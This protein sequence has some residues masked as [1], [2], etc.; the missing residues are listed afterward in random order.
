M[1]FLS[2][3]PERYFSASWLANL[4]T[5]ANL[6][7]GFVAI[8]MV[9]EGRLAAAAWLILLCLV[10][11]SLDGNAARRLK[12][13]TPFGRELDSLADL[14]SF[15]VAPALL[16]LRICPPLQASAALLYLAAGAY[17]LAR[18]NVRP[19]TRTY[20][21]GLPVPAAAATLASVVLAFSRRHTL[22]LLGS[23][24]LLAALMAVLSVL[25]VSYLRYPKL[26][27]IQFSRWRWLYAGALLVFLA[28]VWRVDVEAGLAWVCLLFAALGPA[29]WVRNRL[30]AVP[31]DS[32]ETAS[33]L[34]R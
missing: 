6:F 27:A 26:S 3:R 4:I 31:V 12:T 24:S 19:A 22:T 5:L 14:V 11:D 7:S 8:L 20:F 30:F 34:S 23:A 25:M 32:C 29:S 1:G 28:S 9:V 18:F 2:H 16:A 17:R 21:E 13:S 10:W 33:S 15:V